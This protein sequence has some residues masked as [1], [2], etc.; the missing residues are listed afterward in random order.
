MYPA[1][2]VFGQNGRRCRVSVLDISLHGARVRTVHRLRV[3]ERF[4]LKLPGLTAIATTVAW[5]RDFIVGCEFTDPLHPAMLDALL[6]GKTL[7]NVRAQN[8]S[9]LARCARLRKSSY[10]LVG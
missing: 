9:S 1:C 10:R 7:D 2:A 3:G 5:S 8:E 6:S 4:W